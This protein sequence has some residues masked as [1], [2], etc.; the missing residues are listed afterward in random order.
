M[1]KSR[2]ENVRIAGLASAVPSTVL[3]SEDDARVFGEEEIRRVVKNTGVL[4][5]HVATRLCFSDMGQRAAETLLQDLGWA[6]D[7]VDVLVV[8][9]Q[10]GDYLTP[11]TACVIQHRLGLSSQCAALDINLGCSGYVYGLFVL[12]SMLSAGHLRRGLLLVGDTATRA[13][14]PEDRAMLP[15]FGDAGCATAV[16]FSQGA[17]PWHFVLGTDGSGG[18][19]LTNKWGGYRNQYTPAAFEWVTDEDGVQRQQKHTYM[20]GAEVLSFALRE[21]PPLIQQIRDFSGWSDDRVD[22]YVFHQA[23]SFLL[24]NIGRICRLPAAKVTVGL[25]NYGNT[26]S[27]SIPLAMNSELRDTLSTKTQNL[28]LG[29]FGIGWSFAAGTIPCGPI[30]VPQVIVLADETTTVDF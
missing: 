22:H 11:A 3:T 20:N 16:E 24:K 14:A 26:S 25:T 21:V 28:F 23:S 5:R 2:I 30:V 15:L 13:T 12:G 19:H 29:G 17:E 4:R 9:T 6:R 10:S 1:S 7:S 18:K 8:V 27:A